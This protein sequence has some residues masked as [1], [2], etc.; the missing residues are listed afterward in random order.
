LGGYNYF[1][2]G[3]VAVVEVV[4]FLVLCFDAVFL[5]FL[6]VLFWVAV[7]WLGAGAVFCAKVRGRVAAAKTIASKLFFIL[8]L[9]EGLSC[10]VYSILR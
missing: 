6:A 1:C 5:V 2:G 3:V 10:P 7:D 9:L 8:I 4:L